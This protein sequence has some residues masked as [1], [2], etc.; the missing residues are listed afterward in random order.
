VVLKYRG[1]LPDGREFD[2]S[3]GQAEFS[4]QEVIPGWQ[5]ALLQ[6][7]EGAEWELYIPPTLAHHGATRNRGALGQQPLIYQVEL[8]EIK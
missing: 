5:E 7:Q 1:T 6:M 3:D 4:V 8:V 2:R